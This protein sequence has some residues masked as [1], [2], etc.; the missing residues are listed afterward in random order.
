MLHLPDVAVPADELSVDLRPADPATLAPEWLALEE[1]AEPSFFQSWGWIGSWLDCLPPELWPE[2]VEVRWRGT[3]IGLGL[4]VRRLLVRRGVMRTRTLLLHQAGDVALDSIYIEHNGLLSDRQMT[5][6]VE[7]RVVDWL[8]ERDHDW[9]ELQ[10]S[11]VP[12]RWA[13][14]ATAGGLHVWVR[15]AQPCRQRD[16]RRVAAA[17]GDLAACLSRNT[18]YQLRR[19]QRLAERA[20]PLRLRQ[21]ATVGEA[22]A[23]FDV[24]KALHIASWQRRGRPHAFTHAFFEQFHRNLIDARFAAGEIQL[25]Q[26]GA[27]GE[28]L[29]YLYNFS[30]RGHVYAY[31][32]GFAAAADRHAKPGLV[33]HALAIEHCLDQGAHTYDFLAGD[34]QLKLSLADQVSELVWLTLQRH[35]L[36][37]RLERGLRDLKSRLGSRRQRNQG[38]DPDA[39]K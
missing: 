32:S 33:A 10:V 5:A 29:A 27:G 39:P 6:A 26:I 21:A 38:L 17:G 31:Q 30:H 20:G 2:V 24:L 14:L 34:N 16:L 4:L 8:V 22:H 13:A 37:L 36:P 7:Q 28:A 15:A 11:G 3:V 18:R 35:R 12:A 19:A 25:L 23:F 1:R 9:D